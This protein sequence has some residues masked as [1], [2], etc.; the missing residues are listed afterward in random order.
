MNKHY[1]ESVWSNERFV[2]K[3]CKLPPVQCGGI[4]TIRGKEVYG[5][6]L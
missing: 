1:W 3:T 5:K 2:C 6:E 4:I